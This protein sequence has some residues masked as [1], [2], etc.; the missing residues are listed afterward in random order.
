MSNRKGQKNVIKSL[1]YLKKFYKNIHY[2]IVGKPY[3]KN[4]L[5]E[6]ASELN[7]LDNV[8]FYES[9]NEQKKYHYL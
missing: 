9:A 7:V 5:I 4:E 3:I 8:S 1:P 6:L 2:T